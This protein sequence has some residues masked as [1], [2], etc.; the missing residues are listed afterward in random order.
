[1]T[2]NGG[3]II[4]QK[5]HHDQPQ[6]KSFVKRSD[7]ASVLGGHSTPEGE[8]IVADAVGLSIILRDYSE[9]QAGKDICDRVYGAAKSRLKAS[10]HAGNDVI[11]ASDMK[12]GTEHEKKRYSNDNTS[13]FRHGI[14]QWHQTFESGHGRNNRQWGA[15]WHKSNS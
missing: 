11:S 6:I 13:T 14:L 2:L 15:S 5:F 8:K 1:V 12:K 10:M 3:Q 9:C 7:N 4:L